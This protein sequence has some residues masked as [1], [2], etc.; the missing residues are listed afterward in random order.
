MDDLIKSVAGAGTDGLQIAEKLT[1][2]AIDD[3]AA[4]QIKSDTSSS[5]SGLFSKDKE[6]E[7]DEYTKKMLER[8][9]E[10][11]KKN[12]TRLDEEISKH[13]LEIEY[14]L[15][16]IYIKD[17]NIDILKLIITG[18][19][20]SL[21]ILA[22][23]KYVVFNLPVINIISI[24]VSIFLFLIIIRVITNKDR[25]PLNFREFN[26]SE[27]PGSGGF[28]SQLKELLLDNIPIPSIHSRKS[29]SD[30]IVEIPAGNV[31][32]G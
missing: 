9:H 21:L 5:S 7:E 19:L 30:E 22:V 15:N 16:D 18:A 24:V 4:L 1:S 32:N 25:K 13:K 14:K 6:D 20:L 29:S 2:Q 8:Y 12:N 3:M 31:L 28:F 17:N 27:S 26:Y 11:L 23:N 10:Y